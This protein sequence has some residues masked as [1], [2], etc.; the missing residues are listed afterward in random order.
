MSW[1]KESTV[2]TVVLLGREL[3]KAANMSTWTM[4]LQKKLICPAVRP[5]LKYNNGYRPNMV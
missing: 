3:E 2:E 5:I 1:D 4:S